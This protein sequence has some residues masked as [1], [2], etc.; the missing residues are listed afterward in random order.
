[1][2]NI[3]FV[4]VLEN[5][6]T[7]LNS[8]KQI[9]EQE[10]VNYLSTIGK[11]TRLIITN[12]FQQNKSKLLDFVEN[13][14][15]CIV[16][17][18]TCIE[19]LDI[20]K[21]EEILLTQLNF[22]EFAISNARFPTV[23]FSYHHHDTD[24][25][26]YYRIF[27]E[28]VT[29]TNVING[30]K[31]IF[32]KKDYGQGAFYICTIDFHNYLN[33]NGNTLRSIKSRFSE[34]E[35]TERITQIDKD[36]ITFSLIEVIKDIFKELSIPWIDFSYFPKGKDNAF[37][38][39]IDVDG[40][41]VSI[42]KKISDLGAK[43]KI[44]ITFYLNKSLI[45]ETD[46]TINEIAEMDPLHDL[47]NHGTVHNIHEDYEWN[48]SNLEECS[49]WMKENF[50][51]EPNG[52]VA[53]RGIWNSSLEKA[54]VK[55]GFDYSSDFGFFVNGLPMRPY[56]NNK[57]S[58]I[59][60]LP[61]NPYNVGR[62]EIYYQGKKDYLSDEEIL[63][64]YFSYFTD[65]LSEKGS[66]LIHIFGHPHGLGKREELIESLFKF[67]SKNDISPLSIREFVDWW[68]Y[69]EECEYELNYVDDKYEITFKRN[70]VEFKLE[71]NC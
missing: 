51:V 42:M 8:W 11:H 58:D 26:G 60:Q 14:G 69:R 20:Y 27:E 45:E 18:P 16:Q 62:A 37:L 32:I 43:Y 29:K 61:V 71:N 34:T 22:P 36:L 59:L 2:E 10:K 4:T 17:Q 38:M 63:E 48:V 53:P 70:P 57:K 52:F 25:V 15:T 50:G 47:A 31:P 5:E 64:Y 6:E 7:Q 56:I 41:N 21:D 1:M 19:E 35:V 28:R 65:V 3:I 24:T 30:V 13:G 40:S 39:R 9:L 49:G 55:L 46:I 44:P 12:A 67:V 23:G 68:K 66:G 33:I 54:L